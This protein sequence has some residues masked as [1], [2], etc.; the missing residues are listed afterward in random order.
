MVID[1]TLATTEVLKGAEDGRERVATPAKGIETEL[2]QAERWLLQLMD[3][4]PVS[5]GGVSSEMST[6][7]PS[8]APGG[9]VDNHNDMSKGIEVCV[10]SFISSQY[11]TPHISQAGTKAK[12]LPAVSGAPKADVSN[13][14]SKGIDVC[15][16][17]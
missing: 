2:K 8:V 10:T 11:L 7:P 16:L 13:D 5:N 6:P 17:I 14:V 15:V 12:I 3:E 9:N 1:L 4:A